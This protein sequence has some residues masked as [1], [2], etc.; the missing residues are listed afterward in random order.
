MYR[1]AMC[2]PSDIR[3]GMGRMD[4]F[5]RSAIWLLILLTFVYF[6]IIALHFWNRKR[7]R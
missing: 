1:L 7:H 4:A 2:L 5:H 6:S 3:A